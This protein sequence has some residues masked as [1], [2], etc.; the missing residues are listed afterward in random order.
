MTHLTGQEPDSGSES[1]GGSGDDSKDGGDKKAKKLRRQLVEYKLVEKHVH[2]A[3]A[4]PLSEGNGF[5]LSPCEKLAGPF[6]PS[7]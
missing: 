4:P 7:L 3:G 6:I 2:M 5:V 1:S